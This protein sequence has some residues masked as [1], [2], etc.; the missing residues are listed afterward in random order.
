[1]VAGG[2]SPPSP[3]ERY[4][5]SCSPPTISASSEGSTCLREG[6]VLST[7][8]YSPQFRPRGCFTE[9]IGKLHWLFREKAAHV[10]DRACVP[11]GS[12]PR[13]IHRG[14]SGV[15][16]AAQHHDRGDLHHDYC[17]PACDSHCC[18]FRRS[19]TRWNDALDGFAQHARA[20]C[21]RNRT[22]TNGRRR[23]RE[24]CC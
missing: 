3:V 22:R 2:A 6:N 18:Q 10:R 4:E 8:P 23:C 7:L 16:N 5:Y 12:S 17:W 20:G 1:M 21:A 24:G 14:D 11:R 15:T 13:L 19:C 9:L